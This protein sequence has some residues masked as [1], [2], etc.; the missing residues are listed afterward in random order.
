MSERKN[1]K[2][3]NKVEDISKTRVNEILDNIIEQSRASIKIDSFY[4][5][6]VDEMRSIDGDFFPVVAKRF[7][8]AD[9]R[10]RAILLQLFRHYDG[11]EHINF[12]QEFVK[13]GTYLPRTGLTILEV[14]N[15]SDAML[16]DGL[17]SMLLDLDHLTQRIKN[18]IEDKT[19]G[20]PGNSGKD[21]LEIIDEYYRKPA[22]VRAGILC[23]LVDEE[24]IKAADFFV[25]IIEK[26][27]GEA[28]LVL[29]AIDGCSGLNSL[30]ILE[31][32]FRKTKLKEIGKTIRKTVH[33]LKQKGIKASVEISS[34]RPASSVFKTIV[35]PESRAIISDVDAEGFRLVFMMKPVT[36]YEYKLFNIIINDIKGIH[37]IEVINS[38]R[39]ECQKFV[40]SLFENKKTE[41][42]E[43]SPSAAVYIVEEACT[44]T[45]KNGASLSANILQWRTVFSDLAGLCKTPLIYD[46]VEKE[47]FVCA[48]YDSVQLDEVFKNTNIVFWYIMSEQAKEDWSKLTKILNS[49]I[50]LSE[51]QKKEQMSGLAVESAAVFFDPE[52]LKVFKR[53][54][55]EMAFF[56]Y[57]KGCKDIARTVLCVAAHIGKDQVV[58]EEELFCTEIISR[59]FEIFQQSFKSNANDRDSSMMNS[60]GVSSLI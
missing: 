29:K 20:L 55:E 6:S 18:W 54:L 53:R 13:K 49:S 21:Y 19:T 2:N 44:I 40:D 12:L 17:A 15:R 8:N 28:G 51:I 30:K 35:L 48:N 58:P 34:P 7:Q 37:E 36:T 56:Q 43:V 1:M 23:Q 57:E 11:L 42:L 45:E 26:E 39:K 9:S 41:F 59:G 4:R 16:E 22:T 10:Q 27:K 14:L 3:K 47:G 24:G 38:F 52:R 32:V 33:A 31:E 5:T 46:C 25:K 60:G 50:V